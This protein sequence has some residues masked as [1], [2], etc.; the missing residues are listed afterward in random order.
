MLAILK[1][2]PKLRLFSTL[3]L[4]VGTLVPTKAGPR[5]GATIT[6]VDTI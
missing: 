5:A 1:T 3:L 2:A 4:S 6:Y